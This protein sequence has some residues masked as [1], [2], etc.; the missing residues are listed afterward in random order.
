MSEAGLG[1]IAERPDDSGKIILGEEQFF[2]DLL[3]FVD[4]VAVLDCIAEDVHHS[5]VEFEL[6]RV[7]CGF[8]DLV[9]HLVQVD[10]SK[11]LLVG[12]DGFGLFSEVQERDRDCR[13]RLAVAVVQEAFQIV[14]FLGEYSS[15]HF[16]R[17]L[18]QQI[19]QHLLEIASVTPVLPANV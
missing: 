5:E 7:A 8:Q 12:D 6:G 4:Q 3:S 11:L 2:D 14:L 13:D 18:G 19:A 10:Q 15:D 17:S 1:G 9:E 16:I